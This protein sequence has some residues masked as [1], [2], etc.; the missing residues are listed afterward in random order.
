VGIN[1]R[2]PRADREERDARR[3]DRDHGDTDHQHL[4]A[5][6]RRGW[7]RSAAAGLDVLAGKRHTAGRRLSVSSRRKRRRLRRCDWRR[8]RGLPRATSHRLTG[9][10]QGSGDVQSVRVG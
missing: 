3:H 4:S 9:N 5:P 8:E 7:L 10:A 1:L 2:A 6:A